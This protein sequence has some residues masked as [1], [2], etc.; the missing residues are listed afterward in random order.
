MS[1]QVPYT[2]LHLLI[3]PIE[4]CGMQLLETIFRCCEMDEHIA[5]WCSAPN[6]KIRLI[7]FFK[8][9]ASTAFFYF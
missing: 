9:Q 5:L 7:F 1:N 8:L 3:F 6:E 4:L 2:L